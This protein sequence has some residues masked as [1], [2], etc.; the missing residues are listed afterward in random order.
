MTIGTS[1]IRDF[2]ATGWIAYF[3]GTPT[4]IARQRPVD[5][6]DPTTGTALIANVEQGVRRRVSDYPD[7]SHP[8]GDAF[9]RTLFDTLSVGSA[10]RQPDWGRPRLGSRLVADIGR[11]ECR[12]AGQHP[13]VGRDRNEADLIADR[14]ERIYIES[15]RY[16]GPRAGVADVD[17]RPHYFECRYF[18]YADAADAYYVWPADEQAVA[19]ELERWAIYVRWNHRYLAG[20]VGVDSQLSPTRFLAI[21]FGSRAADRGDHFHVNE[22]IGAWKA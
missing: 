19:W 22:L 15:D 10:A 9:Q 13:A 16:D 11:R 7:F 21:P 2:T 14:F 20:E 8:G 5:G 1:S 6:W 4:L 17:G 3:T 12:T 18:D